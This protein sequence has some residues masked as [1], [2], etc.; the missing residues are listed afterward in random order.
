[1]AIDIYIIFLMFFTGLLLSTILIVFSLKRPLRLKSKMSLCE[2]CNEPFYWYQLIPL[3]SYFT[4]KRECPYCHKK[5]NIFYYILELIGAILFALSYTIYGFSYEMLIMI[6]ISLLAISIYVSD[7]KYFII[8]DEPLIFFGVL[9]LVLKFIFFGFKTFLISVV[10][11]I[12]IFMFMLVVKKIGAL[13]FKR[14]SIGGGDIKLACLFGFCLG[15]RLSIVS[16]VIG[17]FLAFPLAVYYSLTNKDKEI[18]FGP[19]LVSGLFLVFVFMAPI[20]RFISIIFN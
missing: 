9:I 20:N 3:L 16:L 7:F 17:S 5:L 15:I 19:F 18:P 11:G 8:L 1:M 2:E 12:L 6:I 10:S 14:D 4:N 13:V